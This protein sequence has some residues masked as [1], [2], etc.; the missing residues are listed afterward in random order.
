MKYLRVVN[1]TCKRGKREKKKKKGKGE[2]KICILKT[3]N[4]QI[5]VKKFRLNV[6]HAANYL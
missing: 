3:L 5:N 4:T 6:L 1:L 2:K